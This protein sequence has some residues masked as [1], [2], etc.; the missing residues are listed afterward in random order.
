M[1][2]K[3][4]IVDSLPQAMVRIKNDLGQD[5]IILHT[6]KIKVGGFLGFFGKVKIEVVAAVDPKAAKLTT[7]ANSYTRPNSP[8]YSRSLNSNNRASYSSQPKILEQSKTEKMVEVTS[9]I[10]KQNSNSIN[11]EVSELKNLMIKMMMNQT[12]N[13]NSTNFQKELKS[14][15]ERLISQGVKEQIAT[16]I[17][18]EAVQILG[19]NINNDDIL[20]QLKKLIINR[21]AS[22]A[23]DREIKSNT[24][25][26]H[27]VGP[28]G[29]GKTT[30]IA[31]L[32]AEK[33]LKDNRKI[34][35]ITADTY[36][37]GAVEQLRTYAEILHA[38]IEVVYSPQ[39]T[40]VAIEKLKNYDLIFMDTAGRNYNNDKF[41]FELNTILNK[42]NTSETFL[43]LS[44]T[45]KFDDMAAIL[46]QF[47]KVNIDKILLT[48]LDE[49]LTYGSI[50]NLVSMF[51]SKLSYTTHGQN[52]PDDIE[53]FNDEKI[54]SA[55]LGGSVI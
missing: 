11:S 9:S 2:V 50:L 14:V 13:N 10:N 33:V 26:A 44:L 55:I 17:I 22:N 5:A 38:P 12:D 24:R 8:N 7:V 52:V 35:F 42:T 51:P 43:V 29:V 53:V 47:K 18:E 28:T 32:A 45:H 27:F 25:I 34:A 41:I 19:D 39:D 30:T 36:R 31:K 46:E 6:K 37:V 49:T 3:K 16:E 4:Y 23:W 1:K 40:Q 21:F 20:Y 15:Y 54:A 48:K